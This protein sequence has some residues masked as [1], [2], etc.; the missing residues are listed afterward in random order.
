MKFNILSPS[1]L[2]LKLN[3]NITMAIR[4]QIHFYLYY[5]WVNFDLFFSQFRDLTKLS[6]KRKIFYR[7]DTIFDRW[8]F[9]AIIFFTITE[10]FSNIDIYSQRSAMPSNDVSKF[11]LWNID[12]LRM[13]CPRQ[14]TFSKL[15]AECIYIR[16]TVVDW[17][18]LIFANYRK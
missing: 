6:P 17:F 12:P 16:I 4:H 1:L 14:E 10:I 7:S 5:Q 9:N 13:H 11:T 18:I 2:I 8:V 15:K 3:R